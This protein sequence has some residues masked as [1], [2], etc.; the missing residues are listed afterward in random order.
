M[1]NRVSERFLCKTWVWVAI[2][3]SVQEDFCHGFVNVLIG[4]HTFDI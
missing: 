3:P 4:F 2:V 1:E